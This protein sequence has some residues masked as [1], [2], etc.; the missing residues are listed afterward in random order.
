MFETTAVSEFSTYETERN[1][2][3]PSW[4]HSII[5]ANLISEFNAL[6]RKKYRIASE[7]SLDLKNWPSVPDLSVYPKA[8]LDLHNDVIAMTE[9]PLCIV[10]IISPTQS[11]NELVQKANQY[12]SHGVRSCW[13]V[14]LPLANIYVF[15]APNVY[16]IY[17]SNEVL[18]DTVLNIELPLDEVFQ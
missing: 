8:P 1:K 12:F 3:M 2:P 13:L 7:L 5:Q 10:E 11:L 4:N 9:P 15:S 6:Y 14:F 16:Q 18:V 17:R